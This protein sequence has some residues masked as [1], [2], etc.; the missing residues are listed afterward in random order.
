MATLACK[1][2][3]LQRLAKKI[4]TPEIQ[5]PRKRKP[6]TGSGDD[7]AKPKKRKR[8]KPK[9][10]AQVVGVPP[11]GKPAVTDACRVAAGPTTLGPG[12][13]AA[14]G[15]SGSAAAGGKGSGGQNGISGGKSGPD[16]FCT[17]TFLRQ[18]LHKKIQ[19]VSGQGR[20]KEL[21]PAALKK[22]QRRR[23]EKERKKRRRKELRMGKTEKKEAEEVSMG[24]TLEL[25]AAK[26]NCKSE[27][28]FNKVEV[29]EGQLSKVERRKEK[30]QALKGNLTPLTGK[31]YK[32]LLSRLEIRKSKLEDLKDKNE[33][34]AQELETKMRWTNVLYK[35]EGVKIRDDEDRLKAALKRK[36][37]RRAQ[38]Q[39]QWEKRTEQVVEKMQERQD[40]RHKNLQKKKLA[41]MERKKS[42][43]RKK[44]RVLPEDL[45]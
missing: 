42:K 44:G 28:V 41:K 35:A 39:N 43:A 16:S 15:A 22:Q 38:R 20:S 25:P 10:R 2:S 30:R 36:E 1:D 31:N 17:V 29:H 40:K 3:Y 33:K 19:E 7:G 34:K 6:G 4:C 26:T 21:S 37:Q 11:A 18:M 23:Y 14:S 27:I 13:R 45:K 8:K 32:Q 5:E 12:L 9:N 24:A